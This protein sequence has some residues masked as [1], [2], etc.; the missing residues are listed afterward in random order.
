[1]KV[2]VK[3][4]VLEK[5]EYQQQTTYNTQNEVQSEAKRSGGET[6]KV[7]ISRECVEFHLI[8]AVAG[9]YIPYIHVVS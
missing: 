4:T 7:R 8:E 9:N 6:K 2:V 1:M 3:D 5:R